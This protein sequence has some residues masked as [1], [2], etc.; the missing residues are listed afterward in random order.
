MRKVS[1]VCANEIISF[2]D[3]KVLVDL[4]MP[5][6]GDAKYWTCDFDWELC[7]ETNG[8][9]EKHLHPPMHDVSSLPREFIHSPKQAELRPESRRQL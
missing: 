7:H 2:E 9:W 1:K 8:T 5:D 4:E 3:F 6:D